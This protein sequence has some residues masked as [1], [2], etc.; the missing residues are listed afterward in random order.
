MKDRY[1]QVLLFNHNDLVLVVMDEG[2]NWTLPR[3][4]LN[5][6]ED[7]LDGAKE[8]VE[9]LIGI[10]HHEKEA[11]YFSKQIVKG[12]SIITVITRSFITDDFNTA[13]IRY[14]DYDLLSPREILNSDFVNKVS[15]DTVVAY[16]KNLVTYYETTNKQ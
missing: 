4:K 11:S 1:S 16:L 13:D 6:S 8:I 7:C 5:P 3:I 9:E 15:K 12:D 2:D 10:K 14:R